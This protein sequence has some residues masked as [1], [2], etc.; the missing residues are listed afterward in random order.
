MTHD[1]RPPGGASGSITRL[2]RSAHGPLRV[3]G[4]VARTAGGRRNPGGC[5]GE[6]LSA[7]H[8]AEGELPQSVFSDDDD[9]VSNL[10][11]GLRQG[12]PA[13]R[14]SEDLQ[15]AGAGGGDSGADDRRKPAL[16]GCGA[17]GQP[18]APLWR[19]PRLLGWQVS[20][21]EG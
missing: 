6:C 3:A 14:E 7:S 20:G 15:R 4:V 10:S 21:W 5:A 18:A 19:I 17:V 12:T 9:S 16:G 11:G 8:R 1:F 13:G 2:V